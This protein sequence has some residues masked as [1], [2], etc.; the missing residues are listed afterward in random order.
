MIPLCNRHC[1]EAKVLFN[2][3]MVLVWCF[4]CKVFAHL[5]WKSPSPAMYSC[6]QKPYL[7][8]PNSNI[9]QPLQLLSSETTKDIPF[10]PADVL[11]LVF[12]QKAK[13]AWRY[14]IPWWLDSCLLLPPNLHSLGQ[15]LT[16]SIHIC[17]LSMHT[18]LHCPAHCCY[19]INSGPWFL[20]GKSTFEE[21]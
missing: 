18:F 14:Y 8:T 1:L 3:E 12:L 7:M 13:L 15:V 6:K 2:W 4:G 11:L 10:G 21:T 16:N 20:K 5:L 17:D 19:Y 9:L